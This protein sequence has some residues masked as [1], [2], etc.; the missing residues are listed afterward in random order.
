MEATQ[1]K[2]VLSNHVKWLADE[3]GGERADLSGANLRGSDLIGSDLSGAD[4]IGANLSGADLRG[5]N[6][7]KANIDGMILKN[8]NIGG[9]P[10]ACILAALTPEFWAKYK[11]EI[12]DY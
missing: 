5:A 12:L 10:E 7:C 11:K 3:D 2:E 8:T 6:L 9:H 1:L 4:L